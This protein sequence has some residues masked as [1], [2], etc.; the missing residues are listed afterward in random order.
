MNLNHS[1][2]ISGWGVDPKTNT[3]Y[4]IV[5]N[6]WSASWGEAGYIRLKRESSQD[7]VVCGI[8]STPADG[9]AC[10]SDLSPQDVCGTCGILFDTA[11]PTNAKAL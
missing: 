11:Y 3:K 6:S 4:W 10:E 2:V 1:V 7:G 9:T 8:D 5:R